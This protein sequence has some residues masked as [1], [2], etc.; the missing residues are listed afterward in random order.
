ML[1]SSLEL[2]EEF[3]TFLAYWDALPRER[4]PFL[5]S[6]QHITPA[7]FGGV[8]QNIGIAERIGDLDMRVLF[9]GSGIERVS[10]IK[11]TGQNYY[12]LLPQEFVK[13]LSIFHAYVFEIPCGAYVGDIVTTSSGAQYL[14][15][16]IQYPMVNEDGE[17]KYLL[18]Y[19]LG[20]KPY[21]EESDRVSATIGR[22]NIKEMHYIDMG[23]GAPSAH[24]ENFKFYR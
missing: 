12:D 2:S 3:D 19:G 15:E 5:P 23:A 22:A 20:R 8:I 16:T 13:P 6:K 14:Y 1:L 9:Y 11:V 21:G 17:V 7:R 4:H 24:I 10:G 18:V